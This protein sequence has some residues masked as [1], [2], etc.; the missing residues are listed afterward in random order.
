MGKERK[1]N[2]SQ[3]K[4]GSEAKNKL[5]HFCQIA[6]RILK[7]QGPKNR[8][9]FGFQLCFPSFSKFLQNLQ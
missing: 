1:E 7:N 9:T 3:E 2:E 8:R 6:F 5:D 4:E